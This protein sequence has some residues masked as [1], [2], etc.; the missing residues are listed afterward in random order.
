[1]KITV[2]LAGPL[3]VNGIDKKGTVELEDGSSVSLLLD[4]LGV[5]KEHAKYVS[6]FVNGKEIRLS[7]G[8]NDNDQVKLFLPLGG[9]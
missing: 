2:E 9:G 1:M 6:A 3:H 5:R 7:S 4:K 8:L